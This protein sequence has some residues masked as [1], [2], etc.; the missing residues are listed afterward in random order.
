MAVDRIRSVRTDEFR[1]IRNFHTDRPL[2]QLQYRQDYATFRNLRELL[3]AQQLSPLQASYHA[4]KLRPAEE[5]YQLASDPEQLVN[6]ADNPS[7]A[8]VLQHHRDLLSQWVNQTDDQGQYPE[9]LRSLERVYDLAKG[10]V[11]SPEFD[12]FRK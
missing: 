6:L 7:F 2:Y 5:L 8:A 3:Q 11:A 1:Y 9:S 4:G 12:S 10:R